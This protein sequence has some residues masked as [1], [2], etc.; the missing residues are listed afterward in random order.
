MPDG[1]DARCSAVVVRVH[2]LGVASL[3]VH[4]VLCRLSVPSGRFIAVR[5][6]LLCGVLDDRCGCLQVNL[7]M[8]D[9]LIRKFTNL[10]MFSRTARNES[11]QVN[12]GNFYVMELFFVLLSGLLVR[13]E[14]TCFASCCQSI[15]I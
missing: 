14:S 13:A 7:T 2:S 1:G 12:Q 10:T 11:R 6:I 15:D 3:A 8:S 5:C 4:R 9:N